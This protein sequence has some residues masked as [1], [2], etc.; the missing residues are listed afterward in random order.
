[1]EEDPL[2][3]NSLESQHPRTRKGY[4][5]AILFSVI[6]LAAASGGAIFVG[7]QA[8]AD[9]AQSPSGLSALAAALPSDAP[10][11][12]VAIVNGMI[13][14]AQR[15]EAG[16]PAPTDAPAVPVPSSD[17]S[18]AAGNSSGI[19]NTDSGPFSAAVFLTD[20]AWRGIVG[21]KAFT[22]YAGLASETTPALRI[23]SQ[24]AGSDGAPTLV[25]VFD[26]PQTTLVA[27]SPSPRIT[28]AT[29]TT[30]TLNS[31]ETFGLQD[32]QFSAQHSS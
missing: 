28:T 4:S 23:Y 14:A 21:D 1:M 24:P 11:A 31:G 7:A 32:L 18:F 12:K 25:G 2:R 16:T 3:H 27:T 30:L 20:N 8:Q 9:N 10:S 5:R 22:V 19:D 17:P 6:G 15:A 26:L 13:A 29:G